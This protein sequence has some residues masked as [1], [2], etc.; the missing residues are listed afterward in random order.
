MSASN[1]S[2]Q[3]VTRQRVM[4]PNV[5]Q[6]A[7][8]KR[9][10]GTFNDV[11]IEAGTETIAANRMILSCCS[12]FF[13]GMFDLEMKEKYQHDPVQ[14]HGFDGKAVKALIDFMYSGEVTIKNENVMDLLAASDYLQMG[15]VKQFCFDFLESML[16]S[17]NW[18]AIRS[19]ADLYQSKHL[20]NQVNNYMSK[21]FD[22]IV[23]TDEF[24]SLDKDGLRRC[25]ETLDRSHVKQDSIFNGLVNWCQNDETARKNDFS[26]LFDEL[27]KV[28]AMSVEIL[29]ETVAKEDLVI[30]DV[31][32]LKVVASCLFQRMKETQ[33]I[34]V[35]GNN[36]KG[37]CLEVYSC[38]NKLPT[39]YPD[40]PIHLSSH[41]ALMTNNCVY[42]VGGC[43]EED[44]K[45]IVCNRVWQLNVN[46]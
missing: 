4:S 12:R 7:N 18:F 43:T 42:V 33:I 19:A 44:D 34:S 10:K 11:T 8:E 27:V 17:D 30:K 6:Y 23:E 41:C 28:D 29:E 37:K 2:K 40:L 20:Q 14:I 32:C 1:S 3:S 21:N 22:A 38:T 26:K 35:G 25:I 24:K 15:E 5:L 31:E 45:L 39:E 36:V 9:N 13:E 16:S 46:D